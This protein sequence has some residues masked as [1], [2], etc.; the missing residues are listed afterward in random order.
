MENRPQAL[1]VRACVW[2]GVSAPGVPR[3][4]DQ[5]PQHDEAA[6]QG[7][8]R[9]KDPAPVCGADQQPRGTGG[10]PGVDPLDHQSG[11]GLKRFAF[12]A[13]HPVGPEPGEQGPELG[14][15]VTG[16][17]V[18]GDQ[19]DR[20]NPMGESFPGMGHISAESFRLAGVV[21]Q[22]SGMPLPSVS[23]EHLVPSLTRSTM[24]CPAIFPPQEALRCTRPR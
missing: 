4:A 17:Q 22:S 8:H 11:A 19:W 24:D 6:G 15:I 23:T 20:W 3:R 9:V 18:R 5:V 21:T 10:V 7:D 13:D 2:T 14:A 16:V 12:G 1:A